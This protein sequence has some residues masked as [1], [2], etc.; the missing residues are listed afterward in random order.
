MVGLTEPTGTALPG[1]GFT[2]SHQKLELEVDFATRSVKGKTEITII[3]SHKDLRSIRLHCRQCVLKRI[4]I[5]GRGPTIKYQEPYST[6]RMSSQAGVHQHHMLRKKLSMQLKEPPEEELVV[7]LPKNVRIE[8]VDPFS[9]ELQNDQS[10]KVEST[11]K[12][13]N[14]DTAVASPIVGPKSAD[15][16][17][18][19]FRPI[20]LYIE[21]VVENLRDGLQFVGCEEGDSRYPHVYTTNNPHQGSAS[22][23]FPCVDSITSRC[24]WDI[25]IK[26]P[27]T[28]GDI[29]KL[30]Q[31]K[32]DGESPGLNRDTFD[33][34]HE[35]ARA[36]IAPP[37]QEKIIQDA[38]HLTAEDSARELTIVCSGE[39]ADEVSIN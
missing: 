19:R 12:R 25:S 16:Q 26:C 17:A 23:L 9:I 13:D 1:P 10:V 8:E 35:K 20:S 24:T 21:F 28:L 7:N 31:I 39:L 6:L 30:K 2:V 32:K 15:E 3:P 14:E 22:C 38:I 34:E 4:N 11:I 5:N 29:A 27:R 18:R 33:D 36:S 37:V